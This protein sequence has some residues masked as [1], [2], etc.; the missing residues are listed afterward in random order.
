MTELK[1]IKTE[2]ILLSYFF[3][4]FFSLSTFSQIEMGKI[5]KAEET[6]K[7]IEFPPYNPT[8]NFIEHSEYYRLK[9][10]KIID[11]GSGKNPFEEKKC[12]VNEYYK[13]YNELKIYYPAH[14]NDYRK[15]ETTFIKRTDNIEE[16]NWSQVG[17][18]YYTIISINPRI[19]SSQMYNELKSKFRK[20][21]YGDILFELK[22]NTSNE[23]IYSIEPS[24]ST[25]FI[26][27]PYF[28]KTKDYIKSNKFIAL[29]DFNGD[30]VPLKR[31][32]GLLYVDKNSEWNAELTILK[33]ED[34]KIDDEEK[35]QSDEDVRFMVLLSKDKDTIIMHLN[36]R[37]YAQW[38]FE[39]I[40]IAKKDFDKQKV[41]NKN[42]EKLKESTL[43]KK[44][45]EKYGK[46]VYQKKLTIGMSKDMCSDIC[47]ITLN[48]KKIKNASGEIEVWEYTGIL[49]LYF[50]NQKLS[51]I[52][53]Y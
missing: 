18:K 28:E 22:D 50:K 21:F 43:I 53:N 49:K 40:F 46:L 47:G 5:E 31:K 20:D 3:I 16:L 35:L 11:S 52:V 23:I 30:K 13:R 39:D 8:E 4:F 48:R 33:S 41:Q 27:V 34:L 15:D 36:N 37:D 25:K 14:S 42:D 51:E 38:V 19:E 9:I 17:N 12:D 1:K 32:D 10:R 44:Y 2:K 45:G 6:E 26:L 29:R 24:Y 7:K